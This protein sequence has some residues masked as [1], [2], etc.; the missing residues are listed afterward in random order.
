MQW[1]DTRFRRYARFTARTLECALA[2]AVQLPNSVEAFGDSL[3]SFDKFI[4]ANLNGSQNA[5]EH[6]EDGNE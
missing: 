1:P 2:G 6:D 3:K 5:N 4:E